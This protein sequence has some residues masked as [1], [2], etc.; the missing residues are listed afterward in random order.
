[1]PGLLPGMFFSGTGIYSLT[2]ARFSCM[3]GAHPEN[4]QMLIDAPHIA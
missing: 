4:Q 1:V 2:A 3:P